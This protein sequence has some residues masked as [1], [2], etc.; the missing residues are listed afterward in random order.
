MTH[1]LSQTISLFLLHLPL[2]TLKKL[3]TRCKSKCF[4]IFSRCS[5]HNDC[6]FSRRARNRMH[7]KLT[8]DRKKLF[9]NKMQETILFLESRNQQ[10][11]CQLDQLLKSSAAPPPV[12]VAPFPP[13]SFSMPTLYGNLPLEQKLQG[14]YDPLTAFCYFAE[15]WNQAFEAKKPSSAS[16]SIPSY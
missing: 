14:A 8:R 2:L 4:D 9:T 5:S 16:K 6:L 11:R 13:G 7:A 15:I 3:I 12:A 1:Q 10:L